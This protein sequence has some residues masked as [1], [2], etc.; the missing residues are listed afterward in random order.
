MAAALYD[1]EFGYY[2]TQIRDVGRTGD[3]TTSAQG[4]SPL[5]QAIARWAKDQKKR[6]RFDFHWHLVEVGGGTGEM[7]ATILQSLGIFGRLGLTYH[8]VEISQPLRQRQK[9]K[10]R[11]RNVRWHDSI[12]DALQAAEGMALIFSNELVDA[13]PCRRLRRVGSEWHEIGL[14]LECGQI[15]ESCRPLLEC[16]AALP[17]NQIIEVHAAYREE[18]L[19]T[20][21]LLT[22]G[23]WLTIDYGDIF[24]ALYHRQPQGTV[25]GYFHHQRVEGAEIYTRIGQ[26]DLTADV[27]FTDLQNWGAEAGLA[28]D[29]LETQREFITRHLG[30]LTPETTGEA[31]VLDPI[32]AGSAFKVLQQSRSTA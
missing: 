3:F 28:N 26:Q 4:N 20:A 10:L 17:E 5:G 31:R 13:Y 9:E 21:P 29:L 18:L 1:P 11:G 24:P 27:N 12:A 23:A 2:A 22:R 16:V 19:K 6:F 30:H 7:A 15:Q 32:G 8:L 14:K 25:R